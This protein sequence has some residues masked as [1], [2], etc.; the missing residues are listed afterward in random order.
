[1]PLYADADGALLTQ[2]DK[3]DLEAIGLIKFDFLGLKT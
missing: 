2:L 3:D 1:M